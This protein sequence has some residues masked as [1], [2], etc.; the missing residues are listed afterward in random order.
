MCDEGHCL[1]ESSSSDLDG[2]VCVQTGAC[3]WMWLTGLEES[4][5][6]D[7]GVILKARYHN[8]V[9]RPKTL[10]P[11]SYSNE[12]LVC[13]F[14]VTDYFLD[15]FIGRTLLFP[16]LSYYIIFL[17]QIFI[18]SNAIALLFFLFKMIFILRLL[19]SLESDYG[20]NWTHHNV[21]HCQSICSWLQAARK[22]QIPHSDVPRFCF[23]PDCLHTLP[24]FGGAIWVRSCA[25]TVLRFSNTGG[26]LTRWNYSA[27]CG[28]DSSGINEHGIKLS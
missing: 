4:A 21:Q 12:R 20:T 17:S 22:L 14:R 16:F 27:R 8:C 23:F 26:T 9:R 1:A 13:L 18:I 2:T 24:G 15:S 3:V 5:L 6:R 19:V 28:N 7:V 11:L 25:K 10:F